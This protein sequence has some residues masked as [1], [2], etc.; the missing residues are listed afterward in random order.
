MVERRSLAIARLR[1]AHAH[2]L[3]AARDAHGG[4]EDIQTCQRAHRADLAKT[5][6]AEATRKKAKKA[7]KKTK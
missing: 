6:E 7:A 5:S 3:Y 1:P 2:G 4:F